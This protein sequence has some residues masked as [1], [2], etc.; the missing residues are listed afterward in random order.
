MFIRGKSTWYAIQQPEVH[1]HPKAQAA[2]GELILQ[3]SIVDDKSF[4]VETHSDFTID[5]FRT[6]LRKSQKS[7]SSG[8]LYFERKSGKNS[9]HRIEINSDG[10]LVGKLPKGYRDFFIKEELSFLGID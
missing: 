7:V 4:I 9:A 1:L 6:A 3:L 2:F 5:R 10:E 8:I